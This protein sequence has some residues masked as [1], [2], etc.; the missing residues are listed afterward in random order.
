MNHTESVELTVS[1]MPVDM[2][3]APVTKY[4]IRK[5]T[6]VPVERQVRFFL[7][8]RD[9]DDGCS[10]PAASSFLSGGCAAPGCLMRGPVLSRG[11][12]PGAAVAAGGA[13]ASAAT[14]PMAT[15]VNHRRRK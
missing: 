1:A 2:P 14:K 9:S 8:E 5:S 7:N 6:I 10:G 11:A 12:P 15:S 3:V 4:A 13:P